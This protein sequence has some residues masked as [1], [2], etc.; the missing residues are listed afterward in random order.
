MIHWQVY[1]T[2]YD[3]AFALF[4]EE[5]DAAPAMIPGSNYGAMAHDEMYQ[6]QVIAQLNADSVLTLNRIDDLYNQVILNEISGGTSVAG[7]SITI[8]KIG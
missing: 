8:V 7:A 6:G 1:K 4:Y 5:N 2:G 3:S